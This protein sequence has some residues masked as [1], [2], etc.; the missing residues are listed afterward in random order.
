MP[1]V[2]GRERLAAARKPDWGSSDRFAALERRLA[3][4]PKTPRTSC[5]SLIIA[6]SSAL[7]AKSISA[8]LLGR[9]HCS[10]AT[11]SAARGREPTPPDEM[12]LRK[13][14]RKVPERLPVSKSDCQLPL[15][16]IVA[17]PALRRSAISRKVRYGFRAGAG[18]GIAWRRAD[19]RGHAPLAALRSTLEHRTLSAP[20]AIPAAE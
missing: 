14:C 1:S 9:A 8:S 15:P 16:R 6:P 11:R 20:L 18:R 13:Q 19:S 10:A 17:E 2:P 3:A 12:Q 5:V 4:P 7:Y